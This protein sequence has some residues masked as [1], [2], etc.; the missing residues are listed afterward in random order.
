MSPMEATLP[1]QTTIQTINGKLR[2]S[3]QNTAVQKSD[4]KKP[5]HAFATNDKMHIEWRARRDKVL[6][7]NCQAV[8]RCRQRKKLVVEEIESLAD[9]HIWWKSELRIQI[10]QLRYELLGLHSGILRHTH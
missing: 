3:A 7:R 2:G 9:A 4:V 1:A 10:E 5:S 6:Q 8:K